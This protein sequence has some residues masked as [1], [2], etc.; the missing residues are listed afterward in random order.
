LP[1]S[2]AAAQKG[3][4]G[5]GGNNPYLG[6]IAELQETQ[7]LLEQCSWDYHGWRGKAN[8][9]ISSA[10]QALKGTA[11]H[12]RHVQE[13]RAQSN[14]RMNQVGANLMIIADQ[15]SGARN[16]PHCVASLKHVL[17]AIEDVSQALK[18]K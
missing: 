15:L 5:K 12:A 13:S 14:A 3:G 4:K 9:Q 6:L 7:V 1:G 10:L 8:H 2:D 11:V 17:H 18:T 16:D